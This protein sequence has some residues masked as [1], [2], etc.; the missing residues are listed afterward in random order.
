[1]HGQNSKVR[2][3]F[4]VNGCTV[5]EQYTGSAWKFDDDYFRTNELFVPVYSKNK[6]IDFDHSKTFG[7]RETPWY[8]K[9]SLNIFPESKEIRD[10]LYML[11]STSFLEGCAR[12]MVVCSPSFL[13]DSTRK[14]SLDPVLKQYPGV[15]PLVLEWLDLTAIYDFAQDVLLD[16]DVWPSIDHPYGDYGSSNSCIG[17]YIFDD[18]DFGYLSDEELDRPFRGQ[19]IVVDDVIST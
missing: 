4:R 6:P 16:A 8:I 5:I 14:I 15:K 12:C 7:S 2:F 13:E 11:S 1:M 10:T 17:N 19:E 9:V 3:P 18:T